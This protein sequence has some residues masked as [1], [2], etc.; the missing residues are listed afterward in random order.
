MQSGIYNKE[1]ERK[2]KENGLDAVYNRSMKVEH[3]LLF[4]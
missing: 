3:S 1:A 4:Y 2:A